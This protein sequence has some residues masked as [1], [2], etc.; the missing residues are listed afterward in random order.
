MIFKHINK[1][2]CSSQVQFEIESGKIHNVIFKN[3]CNGNLQGIGALI[4]GMDAVEAM[5]RLKGI[6]CGYKSTS[7]P[8]QL[9]QAIEE[10]L[11]TEQPQELKDKIC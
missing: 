11:K 8:D 2:T 10:A 7:C 6:H 1:G 4:E 9:A 5:S 3:G